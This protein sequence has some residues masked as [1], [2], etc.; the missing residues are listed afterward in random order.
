MCSQCG[1]HSPMPQRRRCYECNEAGR[2]RMLGY[3]RR[4]GRKPKPKPC[5]ICNRLGL[6]GTNH[7]R[8]THARHMA[9]L[10]RAFPSKGTGTK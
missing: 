6:D 9:L 7:T 5:A 10:A 4:R 3:E 1:K 2:L 8:H